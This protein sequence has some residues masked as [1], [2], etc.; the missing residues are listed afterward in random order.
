MILKPQDVVIL[1]E[2]VTNGKADGSFSTLSADL[3]MS[4]SEVHAGIQ[5]TEVTHR[6]IVFFRYLFGQCFN[7]NFA[8]QTA[9]SS[10]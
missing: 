8:A 9:F 10:Y 7:V 2:L 1:L 5:L 3:F 4:P 6:Y